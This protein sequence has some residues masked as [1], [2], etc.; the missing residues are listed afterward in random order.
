MHVCMPCLSWNLLTLAHVAGGAGLV[1][2]VVYLP[3]AH[4]AA[5]L[6]VHAASEPVAPRPCVHGQVVHEAKAFSVLAQYAH[7]VATVAP[8]SFRRCTV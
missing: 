3:C 2:L 6:V 7:S 5:V 4:L 8:V 1:G